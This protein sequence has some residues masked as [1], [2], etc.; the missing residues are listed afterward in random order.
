MKLLASILL[1]AT[2]SVQAQWIGYRGPNGAGVFADAR[3]PATLAVQWQ[4]PVANWGNS[5]PVAVAGK[6]FVLNEIGWKHDFPLLQCF[7]GA[8]GKLLWEKELDHL[9]ADTPKLRATWRDVMAWY[10]EAYAARALWDAGQRDTARAKWKTIDC[11]APGSDAPISGYMFRTVKASKESL[12]ARGMKELEKVGC[13]YEAWR[14]TLGLGNGVGNV[15]HAYPTP[16]TDGQRLY[17]ATGFDTFWCLDFTGR[18]VWS[19]FVPGNH[20]GD[21]CS[22][23]KSPLL[24]K[25]LFLSDI[26]GLV[27]AFDKATGAVKWTVTI[28]KNVYMT[29][30][31]PVVIRVGQADVL[32]VGGQDPAGAGEVKL[33]A[34]RLPDGKELK[35]DGWQNPGG[36]MLVNSDQPDTVFFTGGGEHGGWLKKGSAENPP[37]A[38]VKFSLAG[39]TLTAKVLWSG[40]AGGGHAG[41][42]YQAGKLYAH[43]LIVDAA[44]GQVLAG[45]MGGKRIKTEACPAVQHLLLI[46]SGQV[47]GLERASGKAADQ[48]VLS[49][50]T[51]DGKKAGELTLASAPV[52]GEK[53]DQ[54]AQQA[55]AAKWQFSESCPFTIAGDK[56]YVRGNDELICLGA[57]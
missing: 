47:Y 15:G 50:F 22:R 12:P 52:K 32:L 31:T 21:F 2:L 27:R 14:H 25:D 51:L 44:T 7:D 56:L 13:Y 55:G 30:V 45:E 6:V 5:S 4:V 23:A 17:I 10:R 49:W 54:I 28:A 37:T 3:L 8:T 11:E 26:N 16:V 36:T 33:H 18:V 35:I 48:A 24:Y 43:G 42:V 38:A 41:I 9:G 1:G 40:V 53:A 46:A 20:A 57:K 34:V 19:K 39:D 29:I